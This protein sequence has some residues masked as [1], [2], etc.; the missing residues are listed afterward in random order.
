MFKGKLFTF[1]TVS[2]F[3]IYLGKA[4]YH[5]YHLYHPNTCQEK[6]SKNCYKPLQEFI[7]N[8]DPIVQIRIYQTFTKTFSINDNEIFRKNDLHLN[9]D[10]HETVNLD[11]SRLNKNN[12][13]L[14]LH[15][16]V[17]PNSYNGKS[18]LDAKWKSYTYL[19]LTEMKTPADETSKLLESSQN[20]RKTKSSSN[21]ILH[22]LDVFPFAIVN[23]FLSYPSNEVPPEFYGVMSVINNEYT[24]VVISDEMNIRESNFLKVEKEN[25]STV[26]RIE[27]H[28]LSIGSF[29]MQMS[30]KESFKHLKDLGFSE[31]DFDDVKNIFT[32]VNI[33]YLSLIITVCTVHIVA[34]ILSFKNDIS[35]WRNK[36]DM[37]GM[38]TKVL[39]W[40]CFSDSIIFLYL[41]DQ[42]A[43]LLI[44]IPS[45]IRIFIEL[46]KL[47]KATKIT[48]KFD[49]IIIPRIYFGQKSK[50][51]IETDQYDS[52]AMKYL[53]AI[54]TPLVIIGTIYSLI[55][56]E[57]KSWYSFIINS[58]A[59]AI[60][61][62]GFC[63]MF[64]Q[65]FLNY[66]LKSVAHLPWKAFMYKAFNT[67]IDDVFSFI[68]KMPMSTRIGCFRDDIVFVIYLYQ[69][70]IYPVDKTRI[71]EYAIVEETTTDK[72]KKDQ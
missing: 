11:I 56:I 62:F 15:L 63:F 45:G 16:F 65:L 25:T 39:I 10:F 49:H 1:F 24:P 51:E 60:Y 69:R 13:I 35:F 37:K 2:I 46:W 5:F 47:K 28:P 38:S 18:S 55:Y 19:K 64:P 70:Y 68:I 72:E 61:G 6:N 22:I 36:K 32:N 57:H 8:N 50:Q 14:Y 66:R 26:I 29:R 48:I 21:K 71:D 23:E 67:V 58:L 17:L 31:K 53:Y 27:Y 44:I 59:N 40:N 34:D 43:S 33:Y 42:Q 3:I 30:M 9:E 54:V 41:I 52:E 12:G 4:L 20:K 7:N